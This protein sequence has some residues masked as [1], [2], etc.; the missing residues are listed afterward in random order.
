MH[1]G[2]TQIASVLWRCYSRG[3]ASTWGGFTKRLSTSEG[4]EMGTVLLAQVELCAEEAV[5]LELA[6]PS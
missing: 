4:R 6:D 1:G 3:W 5:G 2:V